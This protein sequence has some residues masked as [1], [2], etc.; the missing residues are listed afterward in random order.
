MRMKS[1]VRILNR[2]QRQVCDSAIRERCEFAGWPLWAVNVRTNHVHVV[3]SASE[4]PEQVMTSLK[5][6]CT[7]ALREHGLPPGLVVW[8]RHGSTRR[9]WNEQAIEDASL[10][11]RE[12]QDDPARWA[13]KADA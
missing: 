9:L 12:M 2:P 3:L 7:R 10:Y 4:A 11:V 1:D 6:W 8:S 5:A 13:D